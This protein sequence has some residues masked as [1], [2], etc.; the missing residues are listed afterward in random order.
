ME[1]LKENDAVE[2]CANHGP[3]IQCPE[4]R[5]VKLAYFVDSCGTL[6]ARIVEG[7]VGV[8]GSWKNHS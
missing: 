8:Y 7:L 6:R 5:T 1:G 4:P 3:D 2:N